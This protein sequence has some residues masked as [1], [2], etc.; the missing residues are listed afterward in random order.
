MLFFQRSLLVSLTFIHGICNQEADEKPCV[1]T[2]ETSEWSLPQDIFSNLLELAPDMGIDL[3][4]SHLN[5]KLP[6][7]CS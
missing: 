7:F 4:A 1:I 6:H 5:A 3:F 2:S